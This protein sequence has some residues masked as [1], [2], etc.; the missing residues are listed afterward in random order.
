[1]TDITGGVADY[2]KLLRSTRPTPNGVKMTQR[3]LRSEEVVA[4]WLWG[5]EYAKGELSAIDFYR[6]LSESRKEMVDHFL[7]EIRKAEARRG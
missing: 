5:A 4:M 3:E 6:R 2:E 1:M 7:A